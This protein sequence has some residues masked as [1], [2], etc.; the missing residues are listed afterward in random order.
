MLYDELCINLIPGISNLKDVLDVGYKETEN[1]SK[2]KSIPKLDE[3]N[4]E[5]KFE[6]E[7]EFEIGFVDNKSVGTKDVI[8][9]INSCSCSIGIFISIEGMDDFIKVLFIMKCVCF[10]EKIG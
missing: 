7:F 4:C 10:N 9:F 1:F 2:T 5:L 3:F 6:L 8:S